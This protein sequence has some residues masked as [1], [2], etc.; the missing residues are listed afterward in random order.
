MNSPLTRQY[1]DRAEQARR[2]ENQT[3]RLADAVGS[4]NM[5]DTKWCEFLDL[6]AARVGCPTP[7][8]I[9]LLDHGEA[10]QTS[11]WRVTRKWVDSGIQP[12]LLRE[13][14]WLQWTGADASEVLT[15]VSALGQLPTHPIENGFHL[16]AYGVGP[17]GLGTGTAPEDLTSGP[18]TARPNV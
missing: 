9:K 13:I 18:A 12:F 11:V 15:A 10:R 16:Q 7:F 1:R 2:L 3:A 6:M 4:R 5:N 14:E 17:V 8:R